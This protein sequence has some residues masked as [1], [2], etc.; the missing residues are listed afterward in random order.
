MKECRPRY[1]FFCAACLYVQVLKG[2]GT[3]IITPPVAHHSYWLQ[4]RGFC[5]GR[6]LKEKSRDYSKWL[7]TGPNPHF[8]GLA[9]CFKLAFGWN[10]FR[11]NQ[12]CSP[13]QPP[14][15][16]CGF[17]GHPKSHNLTSGLYTSIDRF[18]P[19][20][21]T[22]LL[23]QDELALVSIPADPKRNSDPM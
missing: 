12:D 17:S 21:F 7:L 1:V 23:S 9:D 6:C 15:E 3:S 10:C 22:T 8:Q 11:T 4:H 13:R 18:S 2:K 5:T 20:S 14:A 19:K 16:I